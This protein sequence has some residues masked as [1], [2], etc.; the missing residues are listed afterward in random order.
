MRVLITGME[1]FVG[2]HLAEY[3]LSQGAQVYGTI[4]DLTCQEN[5]ASL[6]G[7]KKYQLDICDFEK[8][9][10][11]IRQIKPDSIFHLAA[12]SNVIASQNIAEETL[13]INILGNLNILEASRKLSKQAKILIIGSAN[14]YGKVKLSELPIK[15]NQALRP[16][17]PYA[18]SKVCQDL[19][20]VYY[21]KT[22]KLPIIIVRPFNHIGPRQ[23]DSF[24]CSDFASQ[25]AKIELRQ[26]KPI[27]KVGNLSFKRDFTDVRDIVKAYWLA[28]NK[29]KPGEVYN[30]GSGKVVAIKQI[31]KYLLQM[32]NKS[33]IKIKVLNKKT[34]TK[35]NPTLIGDYKKIKKHTGW[36]PKIPLAD[37][38]QATLDYW[39][40]K[41]S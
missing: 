24:V 3:A 17:N 13:K 8:T 33:G 18:V 36:E 30:L 20:G 6:K 11:L 16:D 41:L 23:S 39:R 34:R 25:I 32:T 7:L 22:Y 37:T 5:L 38:L 29:G 9:S 19:M 15:E 10:K 27:I 40:V 14:E 12:Q 35:D 26:Q 1:G 28:I 4:L 2:S 31:L 21:Y